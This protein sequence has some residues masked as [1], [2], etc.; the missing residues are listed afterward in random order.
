MTLIRIVLI[1]KH[2][3]RIPTEMVY[4]IRKDCLQNKSKFNTEDQKCK[5]L[6]HYN[7]L[8]KSK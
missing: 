5:T 6:E 1:E 7:S 4:T 3:F 8:I 2:V